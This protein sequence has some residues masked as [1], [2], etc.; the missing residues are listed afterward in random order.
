MRG[1]AARAVALV[2]GALTVLGGCQ[3][4]TSVGR[5]PVERLLI[6]SLPGVTW[7]DVRSGELPSLRRLVDEAAIGGLSTR[8]G[9]RG[10]STTDAYL[11]IGAGTRAV[12]PRVDIAVALDPDESYA[13]VRTED[14]LRRRLGR[15]PTGVAYLAAGAAADVNER[16]AFG[17]D[18]GLLGQR[19]A[20]AGIGRA[21]IANADAAEGF[22]SDEQP[23]DGAFARGAATALMAPDGIVPHGTVG[24]ALL[25]DD[26]LAPF[27]R[28]LDHEA[29][30]AAFDET[31]GS[32]GRTVVLVEASDLSRAAGYELRATP[33]QARRL[34]SAALESSDALL[35]SLLA[36][37]DP[38][39]D[40][41]LVL[42]PVA[43]RAAPELA[44]VLL[45][46]PG[47][48]GGLLRSPTTRRDGYVQLA[49]VAPTVLSQIGRAHV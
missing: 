7:E 22:A 45:R 43:P 14:I 19:L 47:I 13:G 33:A 1:R 26:P 18:P 42:S 48:D 30:L 41:V 44:A 21:V 8:I 35:R 4:G 20:A 25:D 38:S 3:I 17:A 10:A 6:V 37:V 16:S 9:R 15:V 5:Q 31:W 27:G 12:E 11:S 29:V 49:D 34:R 46:A 24:R 2:L 32:G 23:P 40:G 28:R 36:R 39:V